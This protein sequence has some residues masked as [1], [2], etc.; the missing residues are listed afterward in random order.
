MPSSSSSG[1]GSQ[2]P[3]P[4]SGVRLPSS[5]RYL[6]RRKAAILASSLDEEL[7]ILDMLGLMS[8][9]AP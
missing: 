8:D 5:M 6:L 7:M 3:A 9:E 4:P 2:L 1:A